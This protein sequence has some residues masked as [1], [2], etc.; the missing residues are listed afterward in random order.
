MESCSSF[1]TKKVNVLTL[2]FL[3]SSVL[4]INHFTLVCNGF[5][6]LNHI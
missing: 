1:V 6:V 4:F 3:I 2:F 5:I